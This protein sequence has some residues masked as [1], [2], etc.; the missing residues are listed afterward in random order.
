MKQRYSFFN[1]NVNA[2]GTIFGILSAAILTAFF[3]LTPEGETPLTIWTNLVIFYALFARAAL[4]PVSI[5]PGILSYASMEILFLIFYYVI[6]YLP[7]QYYVLGLA[8]LFRNQF[9]Q[10]S[11]STQTDRA[12]IASSI[13]AVGFCTGIRM[14]TIRRPAVAEK[15]VRW[16]NGGPAESAWAVN[17]FQIFVLGIQVALIALYVLSGWQSADV[18]R[19]TRSETGGSAANGVYLLI[20]MLS[21]ISIAIVVDVLAKKRRFS[22]ALWASI[23]VTALWSFQMLFNGDR[24]NFFLLA[25]AAGGGLMTFKYR[26]P[27]YVLILCIVASMFI[28]NGVEAFRTMPEKS[29]DG[30]VEQLTIGTGRDQNL[31]SGSFSISTTTLKAS[32][33]IVPET[34]NYGLGWYKIIGFTGIIPLVRGVVLDGYSGFLSTAD[35]ITYYMIGA[36]AVWNVG[37][38]VISDIYIDFGIVGVAIIMTMGGLVAGIIQRRTAERYNSTGQTIFYL[39]SLPLFGELPRYSLDSPVRMLVWTFLL[40]CIL[41]YLASTKRIQRSVNQL[42]TWR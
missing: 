25:I 12:L 33:A 3:F 18:G 1:K 19:Y 15:A 7:Y 21:L 37:S 11:Y 9:V 35:L 20:V 34:Q 42:P 31:A 2:I 41:G 32:L 17:T 29:L 5:K 23:A 16:T 14:L 6:F 22:P 36:H 13:G 28:Y 39:V 38:N 10:H 27:P 8:D 30:F 24:N 40:L 26:T 4:S